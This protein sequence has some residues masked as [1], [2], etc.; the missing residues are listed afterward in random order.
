MGARQL[1]A[2]E[3]VIVL[4]LENRSFDHMPG[5]LYEDPGEGYSATN[6]QLFGADPAPAPPVATDSGFVRSRG[7]SCPSS[8]RPF[9]QRTA[10]P[11]VADLETPADYDGY[12]RTRMARW[13]A[14]RP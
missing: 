7:S 4:M 6:L 2:I 9:Q 3:H 1:A 12:I 11:P 13:K 8:P 10:T 5:F 14:G